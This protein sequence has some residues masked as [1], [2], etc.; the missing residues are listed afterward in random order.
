MGR[1]RI[2]RPQNLARKLREVRNSLG[3]SQNELIALFGISDSLTQA[4]VSAFEQ[5]KR[6]PPLLILLRYARAFRV[7]V[8]DL[9]D[10]EID[11]DLAKRG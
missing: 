10:D 9:I 7:N 5:G 2:D 11:L 1:A 4:E 3:L 8:D 6:V